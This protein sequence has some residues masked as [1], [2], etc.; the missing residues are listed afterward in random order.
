MVY[1]VFVIYLYA[2]STLGRCTVMKNQIAQCCVLVDNMTEFRVSHTVIA[3]NVKVDF[4][5]AGCNLSVYKNSSRRPKTSGGTLLDNIEDS[6]SPCVLDLVVCVRNIEI[7]CLCF[8]DRPP[9]A[10]Q[11][12]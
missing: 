9:D 3:D 10:A 7:C 2:F 1:D 12:L 11:Y 8:K 5:P 4:A 6:T